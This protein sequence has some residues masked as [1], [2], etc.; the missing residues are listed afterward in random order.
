MRRVI[1]AALA[2]LLLSGTVVQAQTTSV[3]G[4]PMEL[5]AATTR[6]LFAAMTQD[7]KN[8]VTAQ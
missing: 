2:M 7:L 3:S 1:Q 8:L 5:D 6:R 4:P